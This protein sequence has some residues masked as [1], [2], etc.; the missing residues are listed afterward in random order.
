M[1][2]SLTT[3]PRLLL[4][5]ILILPSAMPS[6]ATAGNWYHD[7]KTGC[8]VW[9]DY[10]KPEVPMSY[11]GPCFAGTA[12]GVGAARWSFDGKSAVHYKGRF[13]RGK[14][15]GQGALIDEITTFVGEYRDGIKHGPGVE[16]LS[17]GLL[18]FEGRWVE[19]KLTGYGSVVFNPVPDRKTTVR[20]E[21]DLLDSKPHG[22]GVWTTGN[23]GWYE[24]EFR[25]KHGF[26]TSIMEIT[27]HRYQGEWKD[28]KFHGAGT[29]IWS[30]GDRYEGEFREH[31]EH[32]QGV[33]TFASGG[34][35]EGEF[36]RGQPQG[37]GTFFFSNGFRYDGQWER[38]DQNGQGVLSS[39][40]GVRIEGT[41]KDGYPDG[42]IEVT[43]PDGTRESAI[44]E[45]GEVKIAD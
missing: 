7:P 11:V 30:N 20:Y 28:G 41:F 25:K 23:G 14:P 9:F 22:R 43:L 42:R 31:W 2:R 19:G 34:R 27:G 32:G 40:Y 37:T 35:Y 26:G 45:G 1:L 3:V 8:A 6:S 12:E 38:G 5:T 33:K 10:L 29:F 36:V 44:Y 4:L 24:G 18:R 15:H 16:V 17:G 39:P 21:G 13:R